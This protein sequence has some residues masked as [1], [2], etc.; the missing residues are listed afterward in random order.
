MSPGAGSPHHLRRCN[1]CCQSL[2]STTPGFPNRVGSL[3]HAVR[4]EDSLAY[5][6]YLY[7]ISWQTCLHWQRQLH[8]QVAKSEESGLHYLDV[9]TVVTPIMWND[10]LFATASHPNGDEIITIGQGATEGNLHIDAGTGLPACVKSGSGWYS[11]LVPGHHPLR[12]LDGHPR[13]GRCT[14]RSKWMRRARVR[15]VPDSI[16]AGYSAEGERRSKS[17]MR[18]APSPQ[19]NSWGL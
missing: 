12:V 5:R 11:V 19:R 1:Q 7:S 14:S 17:T 4:A 15:S 8:S 6:S 10:I 16:T 13:I 9:D 3:Q 2:A 18:A